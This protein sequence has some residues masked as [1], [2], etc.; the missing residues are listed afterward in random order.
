M[1]NERI[2]VMSKSTNC[3]T[4]RCRL[5]QAVNSSNVSHSRM[6]YSGFAVSGVITSGQP[7]YFSDVK[8]FVP[9]FEDFAKFLACF[10]HHDRI[11]VEQADAHRRTVTDFD[12]LTYL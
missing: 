9:G 4:S 8:S 3:Q 11:K 6:M 5:R 2:G 10:S 12:L 1:M 7:D